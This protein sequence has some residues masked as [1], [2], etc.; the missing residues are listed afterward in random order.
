MK[1]ILFIFILFSLAA[2]DDWLTV[3]PEISVTYVNYFK[4]EQ[5]IQGIVTS[6]LGN[7]RG[8]YADKSPGVFDLCALKC[9]DAPGEVKLIRD[10]DPGYWVGNPQANWRLFYQ[11]IYLADLL[12]ENRFRFENITEERADFWIAQ[13]NFIRG[14]CYFEVA[15]R[16]GDAPISPGTEFIE[17]FAKR[18]VLEVLQEAIRSAE[19]AM[20]LPTYDQLTDSYGNPITSRQYAS[21]GTVHTL[22]ANIYAWMGGLYGDQAYWKKAEEYASIVI[23]NK[24][25]VYDLEPDIPAMLQKTLGKQRSSVETIFAIEQS[26][27]DIDYFNLFSMRQPYAGMLLM[28]YPLLESDPREIDKASFDGPRIT[29]ETVEALYPEEEDQ[30]RD[31]Y[32]LPLDEAVKYKVVT[33]G[34]VK[35]KKYWPDHAFFVK[36][37]DPIYSSNPV[38]SEMYSGPI[39]MEGNYVVWRL[40]DLI[41]LRAECRARLGLTTAKDD[42]DRIRIRAGLEKYTGSTDPE[43]LRREIFNE[44]DREFFGEGFRYEAIV[45][46][47]YFRE[48]IGGKYRTLTDE[49]VRNGALYLPVSDFAFEKNPLM[50]QNTFWSW[51]K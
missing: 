45:R 39:A 1:K 37:N 48:E 44:R 17:E 7:A 23:D 16:W 14:L 5:E 49:D 26:E 34:E 25:G 35:E 32:W 38:I 4:S 19:K 29:I 51:Q 21:L 6:M 27:Q 50:K 22:L 11:E 18:P 42:L 47:G 43:K 46:N 40:A 15:R 31:A 36:W 20:I 3:E 2:C 33:D 28:N 24:A 8:I 41:L 10:F 30:R 12:E 9:D 13:A